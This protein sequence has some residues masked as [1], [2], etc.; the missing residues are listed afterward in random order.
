MTPRHDRQHAGTANWADLTGVA[1][2][3]LLQYFDT[4][5]TNDH[6]ARLVST[7][8]LNESSMLV[9]T[10]PS[11]TV[12]RSKSGHEQQGTAYSLRLPLTSPKA[13]SS[14]ILNGL[15]SEPKQALAEGGEYIEIQVEPADVSQIEETFWQ[16][17]VALVDYDSSGTLDKDVCSRSSLP[18]LNLAA[19][20]LACCHAHPRGACALSC[21][22]CVSGIASNRPCGRAGVCETDAW[23]YGR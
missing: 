15:A 4:Q 13:S 14:D 22:R 8:R 5:T 1:H 17:L 2:I 11:D 23:H 19:L 18:A 16:Q 12:T 10:K 21:H 9:A 3:D 6:Q 7:Q 20:R